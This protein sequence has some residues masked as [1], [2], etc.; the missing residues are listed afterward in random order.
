MELRIGVVQ[1]SRDVEIELAD[2]VDREKLLSE[3]DKLM[4]QGD[5]VFWVSDRKG[6]RVGVA[7]PRIAWIEM[8]PGSG[9]R[10]V[11]FGSS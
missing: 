9:D 5:G 3:L 4:S 10:R 1:G 8:G 7:V 6:K 2:D 11:G